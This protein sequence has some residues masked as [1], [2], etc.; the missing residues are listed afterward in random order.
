MYGRIVF[1]R[2]TSMQA[3]IGSYCRDFRKNVLK[4][5]LRELSPVHVKALS[6]FENGHTNNINHITTYLFRC[7]AEQSEQ[8]LQGIKTTMEKYR[9]EY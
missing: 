7:N 9:D 2:S 6:A 5:L 1:L 8:F 4:L 3:Y